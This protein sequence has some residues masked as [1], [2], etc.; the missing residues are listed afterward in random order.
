MAL[1]VSG[2]CSTFPASGS[3]D[4]SPPPG[5][6]PGQRW[7]SPLLPERFGGQLTATRPT[8]P[9]PPTAGREGGDT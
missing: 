6:H 4:S 2:E 1:R 5:S 8:R 9:T 7:L 3:V